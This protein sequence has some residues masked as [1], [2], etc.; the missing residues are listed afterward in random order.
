MVEIALVIVG[1]M[2]YSAS[3][4]MLLFLH[5]DNPSRREMELCAVL[6]I[7]VGLPFYA[8]CTVYSI[9]RSFWK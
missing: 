6:G 4:T 3:G 1:T 7:F 2:T 9:G 5:L 8:L